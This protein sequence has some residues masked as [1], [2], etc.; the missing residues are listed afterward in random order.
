[1]SGGPAACAAGLAER[2]CVDMCIDHLDQVM[3]IENVAYTAPWT[4]GNFIDS[5][6]GGCTALCLLDPR[7]ALLGYAVSLPGVDEAHLLNLTVAP[8]AQGS[9]HARHL[10]E[11]LRA[12]WAALGFEQ[13][14]LEVRSSNARAQSLY[15]RFGFVELGRRR[16]YYPAP[17][18]SDVNARE[19]ALTMRLA[20][21]GAG[22]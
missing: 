8:W 21:V 2:R 10:L 11:V 14:W 13:A 20:I 12:G 3:A 4:R 5:L 22:A 16:G 7:E 19:D 9:G 1:M 15:R 6:A 17:A 18:G